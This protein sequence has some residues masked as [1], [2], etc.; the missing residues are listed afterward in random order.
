MNEASLRALLTLRAL[1]GFGDVRR[2]ALLKRHRTPRAALAAALATQPRMSLD[3]AERAAD[4]ALGATAAAGAHLIPLRSPDYPPRLRRLHRVPTILWARGD[5][6]LLHRPA[7]AIVGTRRNTDYG[8]EAARMIAGDLARA[9]IVIVSGLAHGIDRFAHEAALD[10][11]GTTIAVIG[12]GIDIAYPRRHTRLQERIACDGL[13]L[14]EFMPG[15]PA[16]QHHFPRRNRIIAALSLGVV[17][18]EAPLKSGA[19]LTANHAMELNRDVLAVPGPIGRETSAGTNDLI[20]DGAGLV[21]DAADV[22]E[23]LRLVPKPSASTRHTDAPIVADPLDPVQAMIVHALDSEALHVDEIARHAG[24]E[25]ATAIA[26]LLDLE[27]AG[28]VRQ[29]SGLRFARR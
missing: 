14:S 27:L 18:V 12:C 13:V 2:H 3:E 8:A 26:A 28:R 15:E 16:L 21:T 23:A 7:V 6:E 22:L 20:R 4:A 10:A 1:P 24:I 5:I 25:P 17:V 9:G 29:T 11:G 19:L